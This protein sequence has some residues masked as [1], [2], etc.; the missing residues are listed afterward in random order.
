[1]HRTFN[2]LASLAVARA[3]EYVGVGAVCRPKNGDGYQT[4]YAEGG[5]LQ[6]R[7]ACVAA[8]LCGAWEFENHN[9]DDT[10]AGSALPRRASRGSFCLVQF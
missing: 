8:P 10:A 7:A 1:M 5:A 2:I 3:T 9:L 4:F 6:C